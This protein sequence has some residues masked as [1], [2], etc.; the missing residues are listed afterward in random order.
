MKHKIVNWENVAV[1]YCAGNKS[2]RA[3]GIDHGVSHVA[4]KKKADRKGWVKNPP[5]KLKGVAGAQVNKAASVNHQQK[6]KRRVGAPSKKTPELM[7][8]IC[9]AIVNGES[10]RTSCD[11]MGISQRVLWE[12]LAADPAFAQQYAR[13]KRWCALFLMEEIIEIAD[14]SSGDSYIDEKGRKVVN[15]EFIARARLRINARKWHVS[16]T[17]PRKYGEGF[18]NMFECDKPVVPRIEVSFYSGPPCPIE[19]P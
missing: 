3:L 6:V 10:S 2:L 4:V 5:P 13:A 8:A 12:W 11:D 18:L 15:H 9:D 1:D 14:D 16:R 19:R 17:A 7:E